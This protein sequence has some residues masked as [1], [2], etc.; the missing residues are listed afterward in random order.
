MSRLK[1]RGRA[2]RRVAMFV[3]AHPDDIDYYAGG[4]VLN[5]AKK[6]W[7]V[8]CIVLTRGEKGTYESGVKPD[9][10]AKTRTAEQRKSLSLLGCRDILFGDLGDGEVDIEVAREML[11]AEIR[12]NRPDILVSFDPWRQ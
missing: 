7:E 10:L 6:G 9:V 1:K 4:L 8:R 11:T 5:S 2:R 3:G 12:E